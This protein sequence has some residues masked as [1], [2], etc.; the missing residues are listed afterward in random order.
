M[1]LSERKEFMRKI[2]CKKVYDTENAEL[3]KK[4]TEGEFG[5]PDGY[6]QSLYRNEDGSYFFYTNG[7]IGSKY[8]K[9][10]IKR[11]SKAA[12]EL[13]LSEH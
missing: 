2:I 7:G 8:K 4:I 12:A 1:F 3:V 10:D 6:E 13:W 9:E 5:S 11:A